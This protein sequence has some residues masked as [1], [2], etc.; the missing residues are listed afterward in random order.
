M[1]RKLTIQD[2]PEPKIKYP[3]HSLIKRRW[4]P[5]AFSSKEIQEDIALSLFE[6]ARWAPSS[7]NEQPW[8][9]IYAMREDWATFNNLASCLLPGNIEWAKQAPMLVLAIVKKTYSH[10]GRNYPHAWH[11]LGLAL[12]NFTIEATSRDLYIRQMGGFLAEK[13]KEKFNIPNDFDAATML[14]VGYLGNPDQLPEGFNEIEL[15]PQQRK[16]LDEIVFRGTF[17]L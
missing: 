8:R 15:K 16:P 12:G 7:Y 5:R 2:K 4:S 11:D 9:F 14:A 17:S 13:A 10:N 3:I 6:A 1:E